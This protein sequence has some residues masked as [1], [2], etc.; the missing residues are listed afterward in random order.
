LAE[1]LVVTLRMK[2]VAE[3]VTVTSAFATTAPVASVT[4]PVISPNVSQR[5]RR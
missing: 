4:T 3:L 1:A 2:F 5:R